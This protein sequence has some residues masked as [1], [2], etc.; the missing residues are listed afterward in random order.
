ME[1]PS[2]SIWFCDEIPVDL[3]RDNIYAVSTG[4]PGCP[5]TRVLEQGMSVHLEELFRVI[6]A[7]E[8]PEPR[9]DTAGKDD[10]FHE[11]SSL[12]CT[13]MCI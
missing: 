10:G 8:W 1:Y 2:S 12:F 5:F 9:P 4:E 13:R 3:V 11:S 6:L 7:G